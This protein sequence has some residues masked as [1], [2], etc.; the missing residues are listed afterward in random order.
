M[1]FTRS[2]LPSPLIEQVELDQL[3][4]SCK[5]ETVKRFFFLPYHSQHHTPLF[6][7]L[8]WR[9]L[10]DLRS[11]TMTEMLSELCLPYAISVRLSATNCAGDV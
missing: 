11:T 9:F 4:F 7:C 2:I 10:L 1:D 3:G 8:G 5:R 6:H